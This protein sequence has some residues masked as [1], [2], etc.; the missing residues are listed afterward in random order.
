MVNIVEKSK[1]DSNMNDE[2]YMVSFESSGDFYF[3]HNYED[4]CTF[5]LDSYF[6][7]VEV[8]TEE[9]CAVANNSVANIGG[10]EEYGWVDKVYFT[11]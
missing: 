2:F 8:E 9:E 5:L 10:I 11:K 1:G 6:D 3:F 7:D 4:A